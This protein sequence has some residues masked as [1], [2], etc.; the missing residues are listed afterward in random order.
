MDVGSD[1][2]R[3]AGIDLFE[4]NDGP[5]F[6]GGSTRRGLVTLL[7]PAS[8]TGSSLFDLAG[9]TGLGIF[10]RFD[11][12]VKDNVVCVFVGVD[13]C[14]FGGFQ[15]VL[16]FRFRVFFLLSNTSPSPMSISAKKSS[17]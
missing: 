7:A 16:R 13:S 3:R 14:V 12:S 2:F 5:V 9:A 6:A 11:L 17:L 8:N 1:G 4:R 15:A 10:V